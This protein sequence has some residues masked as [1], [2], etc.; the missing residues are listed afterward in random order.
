MITE[1]PF[2]LAVGRPATSY[3]IDGGDGIRM[4]LTDYGAR[5]VELW[6]P[7]RDGRLGDVVLGF[8]RCE[9]YVERG[10]LYF[11][12]TVGRYGNRIAGGRFS[13]QGND[14]Q[15][16]CNEGANHLH[17]GRK[18]WDRRLWDVE[19]DDCRLTFRTWSADREMG[20]PGACDVATTYELDGTTLRIT[21][22]AAPSGTTVINMVHHSYFNLAGHASGSVL[23][24][25]LQL[26]SDYYVPVDHQLLPSG[27]VWA[28][29]DS[30]FDFRT[31]RTIGFDGGQ[32]DHNW[33]L[34][35]DGSPLCP[36]ADVHEPASGRR[37]QLSS[38]EPGV[39]LY[40]GGYLDESVIGKGGAAYCRFAG[41]T[42][43]TQKFPDSPNLAHFPSAVVQGGETYRHVMVL[44]FSAE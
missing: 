33:C 24:H 21:M 44:E 39:Q 40:T 25:E 38:T 28:V 32:Y 12:A 26:P 30:R 1:E 18:G 43:E 14:Y 13:L 10:N 20:Y 4:R 9:D 37:L 5:L 36:A 16:D 27:E 19:G 42:L 8:D 11:G 41:F 22:E 3:V 34:R 7:D 6:I 2:G 23:A 35:N 31:S 29:A 15:L 17:G